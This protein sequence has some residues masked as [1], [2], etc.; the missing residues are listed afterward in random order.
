[1]RKEF[2][3]IRRDPRLIG[4]VLVLPVL[5]TL[6][7]GS[8]L[9]LTV[10][11]LTIAVADQDKTFFSLQVKDHLHEDRRLEVVEVDSEDAIRDMLTRGTAHIGVVI[12]RGFSRRVADGEQTVFPLI[13]DGTMPTLAQA[14]LYGA[15]TLTS[16]EVTAQLRPDEPDERAEP[17]RKGPIKIE[18]VILFNPDL[19]DSNFFLPGTMGIV[20][21]LVSL[22]L[23]TGLVREKE[24]QTIEQLWA[25]PISRVAFMA[26]KLLPYALVTLVDF[27]VVVVISHA[28]FALPIRGSLLAVSLLSLALTLALLAVG[29]FFSALSERQLQAHLL[30]VFFFIVCIMMSG[31][32]FPIEA[33]PS[34]LRP[35]A[36]ALPMTYFIDGIRAL[37]LKGVPASMVFEDF[38]AL[39]AFVVVLGG[40]SVLLTRKTAA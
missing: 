33:M 3:H 2:L 1:M 14:G 10:E 28:L 24:D 31:F 34:Y 20:I 9:R 16:D 5:I 36:W 23:S 39:T 17:P 37:T 13:V 12:P 4:F 35:I 26:G 18:N 8:A 6:L 15:T 29:A 32:V 27:A 21:M 38:A 22:S 11:S 25:T 30:S 40:V 19:R 7:F